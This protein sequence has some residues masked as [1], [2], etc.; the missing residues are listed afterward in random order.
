M[1][2]ALL[3]HDLTPHTAESAAAILELPKE[4]VSGHVATV[5]FVIVDH[6]TQHM[7]FATTGL[8][9]YAA[10]QLANLK[11]A[12]QRLIIKRLMADP[13]SSEAVLELPERLENA[14]EFL[15]L[16]NV[17]S[18]EHILMILDRT[19]TLSKV[20]D[21]VL[22]GFRGARRLGRDHDLLR[23]GLQK[24]VIAELVALNI[25]E[26]EVAALTALDRDSEALALVN[27]A[28]L[29][30]DRLQMS[31][32]LAHGV[33][34]RGGTV[35]PELLEQINREIDNTNFGALGQRARGIASKLVCVSPDLAAIVLKKAQLEEDDDKLERDF[36]DVTFRALS[37][38]RDRQKIMAVM[39]SVAL[40]RKNPNVLRLLESLRLMLGNLGPKD[41]CERA[42]EIKQTEAKLSVLQI[43]CSANGN[44]GDAD[45]VAR[46]ALELALGDTS[47]QIDATFLADL[48]LALPGTPSAQR[49]KELIAAIDGVRATGERLGPSVDYIR[50]NLTIASAEAAIDPEKGSGRLVEALDYI[51]RIDDLPSRGEAY[52]RLFITLKAISNN[53]GLT[54]LKLLE[55]KCAS[56][57]DEVVLILEGSTA[58]HNRSLARIIAALAP[59]DLD[60]ALDYVRVINTEGRRDSAFKDIVQSLVD[61]PISTL[62]PKRLAEVLER[63]VGLERLDE[64]RLI[65]MERISDESQIS[66]QQIRDL[67]PIVTSL[68][69]IEQSP[70]VCKALVCS[71]KVLKRGGAEYDG[72]VD[73]ILS[74]LLQRWR[75]IDSGWTRLDTGFGIARDL[76]SVSRTHADAILTETE[77]QKE[78]CRI[79][80]Q[81]PAAAYLRCVRLTIRAFSGLLQQNLET[82]KDIESLAALIDVVPSYGERATL[83]SEVCERSA[84]AARMELAEQLASKHLLTAYANIPKSDV[85]HRK[86]TLVRI[87]PA[88]FN[89]TTQ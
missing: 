65:I 56:C 40:T 57:L 84:L 41:V 13:D 15:D 78:E 70:R 32:T 45:V 71:I 39:E 66:P 52:A 63:I 80:A 33:W 86:E 53:A 10:N 72:L 68:T 27:N 83:W 58:D 17:L 49:K 48:T 88:L 23:F 47:F 50:M 30:E 60:K 11:P 74:T 67:L 64:A 73:H 77:A 25:W 62:S 59:G 89:F 8:M 46:H 4:T 21:S 1:I 29:R 3:A 6:A 19:K 51:G 55:T 42:N 37:G 16:L 54:N 36:A 2:L 79:T 24:S 69:K 81:Q 75:G 20:D 22:R 5:N 12:I 31:T 28:V 26:S 61:A 9:K 44:V 18:P 14:S 87:A 43:W 7:H 76:A 82:D 38:V 85:A 34:L 35:Q